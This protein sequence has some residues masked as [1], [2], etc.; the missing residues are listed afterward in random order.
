M[1]KPK[2]VKKALKR[3]DCKAV[4]WL[5]HENCLYTFKNLH[6]VK[7]PFRKIVDKGTI[8]PIDCKEFYESGED[9]KKVFKH[10]L[11]NTLMEL[12][13]VKDIE[14]YGQKKVFR[15]ANNQFAPRE[16]QVKWKGKNV[17]TPYKL[18]KFLK[19]V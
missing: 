12:C 7:E 8:T 15:F 17:S 1:Q 11:R 16:K 2:L 18:E 14:W 10:L 3:H 13:K 5:L 4:D 9:S 6:D 19:T